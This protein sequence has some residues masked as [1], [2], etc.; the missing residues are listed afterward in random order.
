MCTANARGNKKCSTVA[1][2]REKRK[3]KVL[4]LR[5][6]SHCCFSFSFSLPMLLLWES[7]VTKLSVWVSLPKSEHRV[8]ETNG[9]FCPLDAEGWRNSEFSLRV[10]P[11]IPKVKCSKVV[12]VARKSSYPSTHWVPYWVCP[13]KVRNDNESTFLETLFLLLIDSYIM[14]KSFSCGKS[15]V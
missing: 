7:L 3:K 2:L 4:Q 6:F 1:L 12:A 11:W 15:H 14:D 13:V 5:A 10:Q 8:P 9:L